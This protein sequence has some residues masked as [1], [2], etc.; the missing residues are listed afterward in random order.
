MPGELRHW[1]W[2]PV[3]LA[4]TERISQPAMSS[5]SSIARLIDSTV[6]SMSTTT[7]R[8]M[9]RDS[10]EPMPMTSISWPGEYSPTS[11]VTLEVP[12]SRPTISALSP[13]RFM[14]SLRCLWCDRGRAPD[15]CE[16]VG[17]AEIRAREA[18]RI[19]G[20]QARQQVREALQ[21]V[22]HVAAADLDVGAVGEQQAPAAARRQVHFADLQAAAEE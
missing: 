12:M 22:R 16:T 15:Q 8:F 1:V 10:C 5:A 6:D 11:A 2:L 19:G 7:P 21:P 17:V 20:S 9:P 13:L 18:A 14:C 4:Y 3:M